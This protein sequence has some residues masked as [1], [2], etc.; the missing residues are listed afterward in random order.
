MYSTIKLSYKFLESEEAKSLFLFCTILGKDKL[1]DIDFLWVCFVG[2]G[3]IGRSEI[4]ALIENLKTSDLLTCEINC[5]VRMHD[6][7]RDVEI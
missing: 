7:I 3:F 4:Y 6:V 2:L 1:I 5:G